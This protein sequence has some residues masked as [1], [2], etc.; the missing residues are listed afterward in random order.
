MI[1]K[2]GRTGLI[3]ALVCALALAAAACG[4]EESTLVVEGEPVELG[5]L[6][7][8]VALTRFLNPNDPEDREYLEGLSAPPPGE[9]YLGIFMSVENEGDGSVALPSER[10]MKVI[11]T[12]GAEFEPS[13]S[14]TVFA[15]PF[16]DAV[17]P[18]GEVPAEDT[19]A[20]SGPVQGSVVLF[21][22][23]IA[24]AENRPLELEI[25]ADGADGIVEL[26][27]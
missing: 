1:G 10:D 24:A 21:L 4:E 2:L 13:E 11:D 12:T 17:E 26:D 19:A 5:E 27:I 3:A 22:M 16:G 14:K 20:A 8:N 7:F 15:F 9:A 18:G 23:D 6:R 25:T